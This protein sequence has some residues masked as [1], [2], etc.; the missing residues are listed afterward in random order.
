[1]STHFSRNAFLFSLLI[2]PILQLNSIFA[3]QKLQDCQ[4]QLENG[5][6]KVENSKMKHVFN[7][8]NGKLITASIEDRTHG[9]IYELEGDEP[10]F[11]IAREENLNGAV[12]FTSTKV[13][14]HYL[15]P[16]HLEAGIEMSFKGYDIKKVF[17]IYPGVAAIGVDFYVRINDRSMIDTSKSSGFSDQFLFSGKHWRFELAKFKD[18][19]DHH[20][21]LVEEDSYMSFVNPLELQGNVLVAKDILAGSQLFFLK[22]SP[23]G[24]NQVNYPGYDFQV[25][26]G[27]IV[28]NGLGEIYADINEGEWIKCY[29]YAIG[30]GGKTE[31]EVLINLRDYEKNIKKYVAGRDEMIMM[32]TWGDRGQDGKLREDF[33]IREID[34]G[35]KLGITHFQLDD[36]WQQ[37]L[38]KNSKFKSGKLWDLWSKEDWHPHAERFP[39]GLDPVM[40]KAKKED[41]EIGVWFHPSNAGGYEYWEQDADIILDLYNNLDIKTVK[42]DGIEILDK[43]SDANL[44]KMFEKVSAT[45]NGKTVFNVDATA[46]IRGGYFYLNE[47]GNIF[48]ENRYTDWG[49]YYPHWTLRNLWQLSKYIQPEKLQIEFLNIWRNVDKYQNED[50]LAPANVPFEYVFATTMMAQP[51]AWF[52][53]SNLP[54]EAFALSPVVEK[55]KEVMAE[56]HQGTILPV[57]EEPS[58]KSWTGFQSIINNNNGYLIVYREFNENENGEVQLY[59]PENKEINFKSILGTGKD[60]RSKPDNCGNIQF[61]IPDKFGYSLYKYSVVNP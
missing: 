53:G 26:Q 10:D 34:A 16:D 39:N 21:N 59:L 49:K 58:G 8:N 19:T 52:E 20:N 41:I 27:Q 38:S 48:L 57:G 51:L 47:Y 23:L 45:T 56:I 24:E 37:G 30:V 17:R 6:L 31:L 40:K 7:W 55:Y 4:V 15:K 1:M 5:V 22:E 32:N 14:N 54:D 33:A 25:K 11:S 18:V 50:P 44:R 42:I 28:V 3:Q 9:I 35:K 12:K 43:Q 36:G 61:S 60:F 29:G 2:L 46:S 13:V